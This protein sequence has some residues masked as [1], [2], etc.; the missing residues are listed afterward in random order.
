MKTLILTL[1]FSINLFAANPT[2]KECILKM[3]EAFNSLAQYSTVLNREIWVDG[4]YKKNRKVQIEYMR[5]NST[6]ITYLDKGS[7]GI[8]NNGM[9]VFW[10]HGSKEFELTIGESS[11]LGAIVGGIA[12]A[13]ANG[14][15]SITGKDALKGEFITINRGG[16]GFLSEALSKRVK[17]LK[18]NDDGGLSVWKKDEYCSI[19]YRKHTDIVSEITL[20]KDQDVFQIEEDYGTLSYQIFLHNRDKFPT[21]LEFFNRK[22]DMKVKIP[23]WFFNMDFVLD[24]KTNL[25]KDLTLYHGEQILGRYY[26][27]E[28]EVV[29]R[30]MPEKPQ[31]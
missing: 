27:R 12:S 16:I 21:F 1:L 6:L 31:V 20:K 18:P 23:H 22:K 17:G 2:P 24:P 19:K 30:R 5:G 15:Y 26:F 4:V 3:G 8:K 28:M 14:M 10:K 25:I 13:A 29:K 11:G 9:T 7:T